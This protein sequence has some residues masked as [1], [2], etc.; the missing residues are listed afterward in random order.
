[1]RCPQV[2]ELLSAF[3]D[4]ELASRERAA[5]AEHLRRCAACARALAEFQELSRLASPSREVPLPQDGWSG[6]EKALDSEHPRTP[7]T[8]ARGPRRRPALGAAAAG[9]LALSVAVGLLIWWNFGI[10]DPHR[11]HAAADFDR[12]LGRFPENPAAAQR[13]LS[14]KYKSEEVSL[15]EAAGRV[16]YEPVAPERLPNGHE[17]QAVLLLEMP[18]CLCVETI[19]GRDGDTTLAVFEHAV[20]QPVWFGDRPS[21][22]TQCHGKAT[23]IVE[24][25]D[26]LAATWRAGPRYVTLIGARSLDELIL[27]MPHLEQSEA[28]N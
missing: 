5:V 10:R 4:G 28:V 22:T 19:Y 27:L 17:R 23:R 20:D 9:A 18:C 15:R 14:D 6:L 8:A 11:D 2:Q 26:R 24:C 1:M 12:Y 3:H 16:R 13:L 25:D 21:V 7:A